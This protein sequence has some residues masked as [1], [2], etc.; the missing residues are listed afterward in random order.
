MPVVLPPTI[1]IILTQVTPVKGTILVCPGGAYHGLAVFSEGV[2]AADFLNRLG[3]DV[4]ILEYTHASTK[5][6][7]DAET[8][9]EALQDAL[10]AVSLLQKKGAQLG[11][12]TNS[13]GMMG[14]S[15]GG[16][17]TARTI[18]DLGTASPFTQV[19]L[20]YPAYLNTPKLSNSDAPIGITDDVKP[21]PGSKAHMFI[22]IGDQD[23]PSWIA[24][25]QVYSEAVKANGQEAEFH[26]LPG[27]KHG[28]GMK[29]GDAQATTDFQTKLTTF[30]SKQPKD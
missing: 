11:L 26:L 13:L 18:H 21:I 1:D 4:A 20:I 8:R 28:F 10:T 12:H 3:Y 6:R 2:P 5:V 25:A 16:H 7:L 29:P 14:F 15:A 17:L 19:I 23:N 9:A 24:S 27:I 30:L 22:A